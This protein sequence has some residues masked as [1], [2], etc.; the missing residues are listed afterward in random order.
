MKKILII[1][2]DKVISDSIADF[3]NNYGYVAV[4]VF[5]FQNAGEIVRKDKPHLVLLDIKLGNF[6]GFK[7]CEDIRKFSPV[8]VIFITSLEDN[9]SYIKAL[10]LGS[11]DLITKPFSKERLLMKIESLLR[12]TYTYGNLSG[13]E[14]KGYTL[15]E[16]MILRKNEI[17]VELTKNEYRILKILFENKGAVVSRNSIMESLWETSEFIDDNTLSVSVN[18]LRK[19]L[20]DYGITDLIETKVGAGYRV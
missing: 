17:I 7:I 14:A 6:D 2:D 16:D 4:Q 13:I 12:R 19:K 5:D 3:L 20:A 15:G 9:L 18:R 11:D 10:S 8:P 1:E